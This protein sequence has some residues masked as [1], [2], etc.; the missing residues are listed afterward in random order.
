MAGH[1]GVRKTLAAINSRFY[2]PLADREVPSDQRTEP[3]TVIGSSL[4]DD[5]AKQYVSARHSKALGGNNSRGP[6][7]NLEDSFG[8]QRL[9][10]PNSASYSF[11]KQV[12]RPKEGKAKTPGPGE[13][14]LKPDLD[15]QFN[16]SR[17]TSPRISFPIA[18][19]DQSEKVYSGAASRTAF[20]GKESPGPQAYDQHGSGMGRQADRF[21]QRQDVEFGTGLFRHQGSLGRQGISTKPSLP[22]YSLGAST[23]DQMYKAF[24]TRRHEKTGVLGGLTGPGP[25]TAVPQSS[26]GPRKRPCT[27]QALDGASVTAES[28][29]YTKAQILYDKCL[30]ARPK[31]V[32]IMSNLAQVHIELENYCHALVHAQ[33]S[34]ELEPTH[35]KCLYRCGVAN[36]HLGNYENAFLALQKAKQLN[37]EDCAIKE[38]LANAEELMQQSL[39]HLDPAKLFLAPQSGLRNTMANYVGPLK[40]INIPGKGRGITVTQAVKPG[41]LLAVGKPLGINK[42]IYGLIDDLTQAGSKSKQALQCIYALYDGTKQSLADV[43]DVQMFASNV[44][45]GGRADQIAQTDLLLYNKTPQPSL[46]QKDIKRRADSAGNGP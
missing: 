46:T 8:A 1:F 22:S 43:P 38:E 15:P 44:T 2:W 10:R 39:G 30:R 25:N 27:P 19:K 21:R 11:P 4:R 24:L 40:V 13:Y 16:S 32:T 33:H 37:P 35:V 3:A 18:P 12:Q 34:L 31:D 6:V 20:I 41:T 45:G 23:R 9:S 29:E 14:R 36:R 28:K 17:L 7:Y 5:V 26:L 42:D